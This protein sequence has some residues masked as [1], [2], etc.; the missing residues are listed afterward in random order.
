MVDRNGALKDTNLKNGCHN[1]IR[2][3]ILLSHTEVGK[4]LATQLHLQA[5]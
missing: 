1:R 2:I 3:L 4:T 5:R